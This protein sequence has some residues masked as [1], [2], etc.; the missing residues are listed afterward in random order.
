[1]AVDF[2][3]RFR[4][5]GQ[6]YYG[7]TSYSTVAPSFVLTDRA[8]GT[9][10]RVTVPGGVPT[11]VAIT[12]LAGSDKH[13]HVISVQHSIDPNAYIN[14]YVNGGVFM[15]EMSPSRTRPAYVHDGSSRYLLQYNGSNITAVLA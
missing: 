5:Q 15:V 1:M 10:Y 2:S 6:Y 14:A 3:R 12:V 7:D 8:T 4:T 9:W 11:L 13:E